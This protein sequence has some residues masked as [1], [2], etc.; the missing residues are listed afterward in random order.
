MEHVLRKHPEYEQDSDY[1]REYFEKKFGYKPPLSYS[2]L[3]KRPR[4]DDL[5]KHLKEKYQ[6]NNGKKNYDEDI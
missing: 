2:E 6:S 3:V 5:P 1:V 4:P